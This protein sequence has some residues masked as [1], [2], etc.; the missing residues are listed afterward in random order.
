[1]KLSS[2]MIIITM[3]LIVVMGLLTMGAITTIVEQAMTQQ[4]EEQGLTYARMAA[5]NVA[6]PF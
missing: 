2:K 5:D 4:L 3:I 1:M 6:N